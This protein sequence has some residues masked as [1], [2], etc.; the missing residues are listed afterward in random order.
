ME[1][2]EGVLERESEKGRRRGGR[3]VWVNERERRGGRLC[4]GAC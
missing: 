2:G 1:D 4:E 3:A